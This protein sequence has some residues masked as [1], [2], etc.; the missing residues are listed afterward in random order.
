MALDKL[1]FPGGRGGM[2]TAVGLWG[3]SIGGALKRQKGAL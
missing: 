1:R 3:A 2:G